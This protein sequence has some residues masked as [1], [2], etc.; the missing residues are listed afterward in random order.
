[1]HEKPHASGDP[2]QLAVPFAVGAGHTVPHAPQLLTVVGSTQSPLG[3]SRLVPPSDSHDRPQ[4]AFTQTPLPVPASGPGHWMPHPL[5]LSGSVSL[6]TQLPEHTIAVAAS[7]ATPASASTTTT[8]P[9]ASPPSCSTTSGA[10][11]STTTMIASS[12]CPASP[13]EDLSPPAS[14]PSGELAPPPQ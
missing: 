7:Q 9:P 4:A 12:P 5:Q 11:E 10:V 13:G 2:P 1:V 14:L 8:S 3:H 6:S